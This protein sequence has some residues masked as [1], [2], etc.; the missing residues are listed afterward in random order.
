M[1]RIG[2][3]DVSLSRMGENPS[4]KGARRGKQ[5]TGSCSPFVVPSWPPGM[6]EPASSKRKWAGA[7]GAFDFPAEA[8]S[9]YCHGLRTFI[10]DYC[11]V[12]SGWE[13]PEVGIVSSDPEPLCEWI[14]SLRKRFCA[15]PS[16][17][18]FRRP[19]EEHP[20]SVTPPSVGAAPLHCAM[21]SPH[22]WCSVAA[23]PAHSHGHRAALQCGFLGGADGASRWRMTDVADRSV[24]LPRD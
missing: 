17:A 6:M 2:N 9:K 14:Q 3:R 24:G 5:A 13:T 11:L 20:V 19:P 22:R 4:Q 16:R 1:A 23:A 15:G 12:A 21:P 10:H 7:S 18:L 8:R